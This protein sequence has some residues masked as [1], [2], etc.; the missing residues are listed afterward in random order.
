MSTPAVEGS[1]NPQGAS[2]CREVREL[3][4][5][6]AKGARGHAF[7][8][9]GSWDN[10]D[11]FPTATDP[12]P[13]RLLQAEQQLTASQQMLAK[14][15]YLAAADAIAGAE[16]LLRGLQQA[17]GGNGGQKISSGNPGAWSGGAGKENQRA[18]TGASMEAARSEDQ[19]S[20]CTS[21]LALKGR[22]RLQAVAA[23]P[24]GRRFR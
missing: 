10:R 11:A 6:G 7:P 24:P 13:L 5:C 4:A 15:E 19:F 21:R 22:G 17:G 23:I 14:N 20:F 18:A 1:A 9:K 2:E 3:S 16:T 8:S 12:S